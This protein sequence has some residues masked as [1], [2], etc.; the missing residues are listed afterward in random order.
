MLNNTWHRLTLT[1]LRLRVYLW[2]AFLA[3]L[4]VSGLVVA[5]PSVTLTAA[6]TSGPSPLSTTLTWSSAGAATC[7]ASGGW[8][9]AKTLSGSEV[10]AAVTVDTTYTLTCGTGTGGVRLSWIPPS[11]FIDGTPIPADAIQKYIVHRAASAAGLETGVTVDVPAP[12]SEVTLTVPIGTWYFG[13]KSVV[14]GVPSALSAEKPTKVVVPESA[15]ASASVTVVKQPK[16]PTNFTVSDPLV[17]ELQTIDGVE[18]LGRA[19][20]TVKAGTACADRLRVT[21]EDGR[22]YVVSRLLVRFHDL[23][24]KWSSS[25]RFLARCDVA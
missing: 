2:L 9:G 21:T 8:S 11:T 12:A 3:L 13:A 4:S 6:P 14:A 17:Y 19:V 22:Y 23:S 15:S 7:T 10:A 1:P 20:G 24:A 5:A 25:A 16:P 18:R